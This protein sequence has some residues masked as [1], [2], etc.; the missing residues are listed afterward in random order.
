MLSNLGGSPV[1]PRRSGEVGAASCLFCN[2]P[3]R[4]EAERRGPRH[5]DGKGQASGAP[6]PW[7]V[8]VLEPVPSEGALVPGEASAAAS[9]LEPL[10]GLQGG[11]A[12]KDTEGVGLAV[13]V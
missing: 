11:A 6:G 1:L 8:G 9:V 5:A 12:T 13:R 3:G 2:G 10:V 7:P 4:P